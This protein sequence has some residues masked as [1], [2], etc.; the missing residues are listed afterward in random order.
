MTESSKNLPSGAA[1]KAGWGTLSAGAQLRAKPSAKKVNA[2]AEP[3]AWQPS[4]GAVEK[5]ARVSSVAGWPGRE[6]LGVGQIAGCFQDAVVG[7][8]CTD[9]LVK[10]RKAEA[11][12]H[13]VRPPAPLCCRPSLH[14]QHLCGPTGSED[15][16]EFIS[17][18]TAHVGRAL[19]AWPLCP[20]GSSYPWPG[21][22]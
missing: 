12:A 17:C 4:Q 8:G 1:F 19:L 15:N 9:L 3:E 13:L 20:S 14:A 5:P 16:S 18:L 10:V 6:A 7:N 22:G 2:S 21:A 11:G